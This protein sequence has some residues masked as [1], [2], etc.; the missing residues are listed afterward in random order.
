MLASLR[1]TSEV[2]SGPQSWLFATDFHMALSLESLHHF[3]TRLNQGEWQL[4]P[5]KRLLGSA[6]RSPLA[7]RSSSGEVETTTPSSKALALVLGP[8]LAPLKPLRLVLAGH[9]HQVAQ[10]ELRLH[11]FLSLLREAL[12]EAFNAPASLLPL[13]VTLLALRKLCQSCEA[14]RRTRRVPLGVPLTVLW[15]EASDRSSPRNCPVA[16]QGERSRSPRTRA[17]PGRWH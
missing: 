5:S 8:Q 16:G 11:S 12:R 15:A 10:P 13:H 7:V 4:S 9:V 6:L 2:L 17:P 1:Y 3:L 14:F